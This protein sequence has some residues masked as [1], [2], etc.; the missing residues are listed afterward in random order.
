MSWP[1]SMP[2][3]RAGWHRPAACSRS[4]ASTGVEWGYPLIPVDVEQLMLRAACKTVAE[5]LDESP[6]RRR[7]LADNIGAVNT[8]YICTHVSQQHGAERT[9]PDAGDLE[10]SQTTER[11][12]RT[13]RLFVQRS[14]FKSWSSTVALL[15]ACGPGRPATLLPRVGRGLQRPLQPSHHGFGQRVE[16]VGTAKG[17]RRHLVLARHEEIFVLRSAGMHL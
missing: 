16:L 13:H 14:R 4:A 8:Q 9:G 10:N 5:A 1:R 12:H 11:P 2:S 6:R 17:D 7:L 15:A 3:R